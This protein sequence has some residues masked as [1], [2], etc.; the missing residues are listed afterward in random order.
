MRNFDGAEPSC[1]ETAIIT[2]ASRMTT[3]VLFM[4]AEAMMAITIMMKTA[5][6]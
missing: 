4:K 1:A 2:G 5:L 6:R 3:G